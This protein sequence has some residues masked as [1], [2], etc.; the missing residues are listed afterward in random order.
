[1]ENIND[2]D[3]NDSTVKQESGGEN[4]QIRTTESTVETATAATT[5]TPSETSSDQNV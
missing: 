1:M 3:N 2:G 5:T 4:L